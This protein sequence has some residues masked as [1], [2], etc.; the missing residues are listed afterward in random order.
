MIP[1]MTAGAKIAGVAGLMMAT[2]QAASLDWKS[3]P[4]IPDRLG[5]AGSYAG[6]SGVA[7]VVAG[8]ANFPDRLP[9]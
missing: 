5:Y 9:W 7:L 8:G 2:M 3:L 1:P 4:P 6:A